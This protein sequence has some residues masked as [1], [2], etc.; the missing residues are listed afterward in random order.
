MLD[1]NI[2]NAQEMKDQEKEK[3]D[4]RKDRKGQKND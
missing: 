1:K 4:I 3:E 2:K